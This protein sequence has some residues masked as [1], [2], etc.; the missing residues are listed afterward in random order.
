VVNVKNWDFLP[1]KREQMMQEFALLDDD[2]ILTSEFDV[3]LR[4]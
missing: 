2:D 4:K 3:L 1:N